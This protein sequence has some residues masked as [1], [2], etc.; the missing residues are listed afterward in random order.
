[1]TGI[2]FLSASGGKGANQAV[3]AARLGARAALISCVGKDA[4]GKELRAQVAAEGVDVQQVRETVDAETGAA[5]VMINASGEK[6]ILAFP[7]ANARISAAQVEQA[8]PLIGATKVLL[9]QFEAP[10]ETVLAA[11]KLARRAGAKVVLDPAPAIPMPDELLPLLDAIRPNAHEA[12][13]LTGV[14]VHDRASALSAAR[15]LQE[16]GIQIVGTQA[17]EEGNWLLWADEQ[18]WLPKLPVKSVDATGAGDAFAAALAVAIAEGLPSASA[19]QFCN[20]AAALTTT[21]LGAQPAL[22]RRQDVE[23][24]MKRMS[25]A[26]R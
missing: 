13:V 10:V 20:A 8:A 26:Y 15:K 5:L 17:G 2:A 12:E 3:A 24:L 14:R 9:L 4:R 23:E 11:A 7:G 22:P 25:A 19:G 18:I 6:E 21:K 1:V 16:Q